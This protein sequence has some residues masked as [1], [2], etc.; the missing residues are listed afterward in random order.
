V[1][2]VP[3]T[4]L[5]IAESTA[6]RT[7]LA[8]AHGRPDDRA[9]GLALAVLDSLRELYLPFSGEERH[10]RELL[11][12]SGNRVRRGVLAERLEGDGSGHCSMGE[13]GATKRVGLA[14][15]SK[16]FREHVCST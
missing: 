12:V 8:G 7:E 14:C 6:E 15:R 13:Y 10:A 9:Q 2:H 5:A 4:E 3:E 1:R 16:R 11:E